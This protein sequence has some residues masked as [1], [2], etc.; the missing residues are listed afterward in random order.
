MPAEKMV[1]HLQTLPEFYV[2]TFLSE[3]QLA[4]PQFL[5][6]ELSR[7]EPKFIVFDLSIFWC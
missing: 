4:I 1:Q 6:V 5:L 3:Q 7:I 2:V